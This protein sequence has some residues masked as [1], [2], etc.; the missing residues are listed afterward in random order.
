MNTYFEVGADMGQETIDDLLK[1]LDDILL[2]EDRENDIIDSER[3]QEGPRITAAKH[4]EYQMRRQEAIDKANR[5]AKD[6]LLKVDELCKKIRAIQPALSELGTENLNLRGRI[7]RFVALGKF[8]VLY[9]NLDFHVPKTFRFPF[10]KSMYI[11]DD[12]QAEL[13]HKVLLRL[14]YALPPN[15]QEYY[16][17]DPI[18]M[19]KS[20][21]IF[22]QL[23]NKKKLFPSCKI[24]TTSA[25]LK[26][27]LQDMST[28]MASLYADFFSIENDC[29]DW[30]SC[31]RRFISQG[32]VHKMLPYRV[33]IF[34][35]V[36]EGMDPDCFS[37]FRRM[38]MHGAEC[39]FLVLFSFDETI[40][41]GEDSKM[42]A[43]ELQLRALIDRSVPLHAV[44]ERQIDGVS[45]YER[46]KIESVGEKFPDKAKLRE[47]L[48]TLAEE[49]E[50]D[51][52]SLCSFDHIL[53]GS[54]LYSRSSL[55]SLNV[56]CGYVAAGGNELALDIGDRTPHYLIG[57]TT[58]SGKSNL[59]H[60]IIVS[61]LWHYDPAE[62]QLYLLDFKE[63]VEFS[64]YASPALAGI[65]LVAVEADTEYGISVLR[66]LEAEKG[67][68]YARFKEAGCKDIRA[69]REMHPE[70]AMPRL[71]VIVDEFQVLFESNEREQTIASMTTLAKQGRACGIHMILATQT[72][73]GVDFGS[74][75]TQFG[76]RIALNC[77]A[78]D[79]KMILGGIGGNNEA[80]ADLEIPYAIVNTSQGNVA[81]NVKFA[82]PEAKTENIATRIIELRR[83]GD[84]R[85]FSQTPR[86]FEGQKFPSLPPPE[87][88]K[89]E[90]GIILSLGET[91]SYDAERLKLA[92]RPVPEANLLLCGHDPRMKAD[93]LNLIILSGL[94]CGECSRIVYIG[95]DPLPGQFASNPKINTYN[96]AR[97][98]VETEK[99]NY[100]RGKRLV[101]FDGVNL[102][103]EVGFPP[104][105]YGSK[106]ANHISFKEFWEDAN[107]NSTHIIAFY[108]SM[109]RIK[110]CGL[111]LADFQY[112]IGYDVS[113]DEYNYLLGNTGRVLYGNRSQRAFLA[114]NQT[115]KA[116]FRPYAQVR[117]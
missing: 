22:N 117:R 30:A 39:G 77:P 43:Q 110:N 107:K 24:L 18:G 23:F 53:P 87:F 36:P 45:T 37:M 8:H 81:R 27:A 83:A 59:L 98:F 38:V 101:I 111:P 93:F 35:D 55:R 15:K 20:I 73:K 80:A 68:R 62:L 67:R 97:S 14:M 65:A 91:L 16:V 7:P 90:R 99:D 84:N 103:R 116:W 100:F 79:S 94:N 47:L 64:R 31:N 108:D 112:R 69:Y 60:N 17:F 50:R 46:L 114:D 66:H 72:L 86:V 13:L 19:G 88:F 48:D 96:S 113:M 78:E 10:Q 57:G 63:G 42:R 95:E 4:A 85:G 26:A 76:G 34:M 82:V 21:W 71:L 28:Y 74:L 102:A 75:G 6:C 32:N 52:D 89:Q 9:Q 51:D 25:E 92:L 54:A 11:A 41:Q 115:I 56:P 3:A 2:R 33:F 61:A 49:S 5:A 44:L 109:N 1:R 105:A 40:L 104:T 70:D 12:N 106:D 29:P 58:G